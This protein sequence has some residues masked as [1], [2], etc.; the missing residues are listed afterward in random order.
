[1]HL[2][3]KWLIYQIV[4]K[5]IMDQLQMQLWD[6]QHFK[7]VHQIHFL[8][9]KQTDKETG[10]NLQGHIINHLLQITLCLMIPNQLSIN[11]NNSLIQPFRNKMMATMK[12]SALISLLLQIQVRKQVLHLVVEMDPPY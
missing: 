5:D 4:G 10:L 1:M 11:S 9:P 3:R 2:H 8:T 7:W 12:E 6:F